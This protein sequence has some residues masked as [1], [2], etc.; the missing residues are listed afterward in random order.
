VQTAESCDGV[1]FRTTSP[2]SP[3]PLPMRMMTTTYGTNFRHNTA[4]K[5]APTPTSF[6]IHML[7]Y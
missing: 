4:Y 6:D 3:N 5:Q 7:Y 2:N 1:N